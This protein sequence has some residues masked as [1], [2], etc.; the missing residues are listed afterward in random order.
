MRFCLENIGKISSANIELKGITVISGENNT[1][2]STIGKVLYSIFNSFYDFEATINTNKNNFLAQE[3][4]SSFD[5]YVVSDS[6]IDVDSRAIAEKLFELSDKDKNIDN[7]R[8]IIQTNIFFMSDLFISEEDVHVSDDYVKKVLSLLEKYQNISD[9]VIFQNVF[10]RKIRNEFYSQI[11]NVNSET[12]EGTISLTIKEREVSVHIK[13]NKVI[14]ISSRNILSL[15]TEIIYLDD[16][17]VLDRLH[18]RTYRNT[19]EI[20]DMRKNHLAK[21]LSCGKN[22]SEVEEVFNEFIVNERITEIMNKINS[23]CDGDFV[24]RPKK[25]FVYTSSDTSKDI[26]VGNISLGL[27]TFIIIKTLLMNGAL[28]KNGTIILDEPEIHLH[29]QWQLVFAE[30]IV[31]LQKE[32]G[33]HVLLTTHSPYFIEAI[34]VYSQKYEI[35]DKCKFYLAKNDGKSSKLIDVTDDKEKIYEKLAYPFQVLENERYSND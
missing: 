31:L 19:Y 17:F 18:S 6:I 33:L 1:G 15:K 32:F 22:Y 2:K 4:D 35:L 24:Y 13:N 21:K 25:G 11:N 8:D 5:D 10:N 23:V 16:P 9:D 29:P 14:S 12:D 28:E 20:N 27:K 3:I 7:I 26:N 30:I 34:E